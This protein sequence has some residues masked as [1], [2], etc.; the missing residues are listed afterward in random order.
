MKEGV[1]FFF[2]FFVS[3]GLSRPCFISSFLV[4]KRKLDKRDRDGEQECTRENLAFSGAFSSAVPFCFLFFFFHS[5]VFSSL[6]F[7]FSKKKK[8]KKNG[9]PLVFPLSKGC[10]AFFLLALLSR[11][12]CFLNER[13]AVRG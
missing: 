10:L 4:P 1:F 13:E 5:R 11:V 6:F 2:F 3:F 7:F 8:K 9:E 12:F